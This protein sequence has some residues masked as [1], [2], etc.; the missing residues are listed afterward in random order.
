MN[1]PIKLG[2]AALAVVL[3]AIVGYNL[4]P[5]PR[6][7]RGPGPAATVADRRAD[8]PRRRRRRPSPSC[9]RG[10]LDAL[11]RYQTKPIRATSA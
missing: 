8:R 11:V 6:P 2:A 4:L 7:G 10:T 3:V 1:L 9:R 5:D